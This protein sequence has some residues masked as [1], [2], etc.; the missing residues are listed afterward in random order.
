MNGFQLIEVK[1]NHFKIEYKYSLK[2]WDPNDINWL[3]NNE[4]EIE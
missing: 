1:N 4:I 2:E 3:N